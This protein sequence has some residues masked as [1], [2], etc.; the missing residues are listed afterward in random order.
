MVLNCSYEAVNICSAKRAFVL[1]CKGAAL[2]EEPSGYF[3][4]TGKLT[5]SVPS[6]IRLTRYRRV[7]RLNRSVSRR[8]IL[9]RD[10]GRCQY[11]QR[12]FPAAEFTLDHVIPQSRGGASTW[13]NLVAACKPCNN[14]K[15]D[16]T[17][18][19][20]NMPLLKRPTQ[21]SMHAKHRTLQGNENNS[22]ERYL[23]C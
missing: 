13:E 21:L 1:V 8:G 18:A 19:E 4:R 16:R 14:K 3:V 12:P 20:A 22:W 9:L 17:P 6:V 7:P 5:L 15:S 2:V 23:F 10:S 11:C